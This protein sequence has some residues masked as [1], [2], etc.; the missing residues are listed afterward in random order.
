LLEPDQVIEPYEMTLNTMNEAEKREWAENILSSLGQK[1]YLF[2]DYFVILAGSN[3]RKY[4]LP[5]IM[6]YEVPFE[7]LPFGK[8]LS[9]LKRRTLK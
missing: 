4:L 9:E 2:S 7:G 1:T 8:L 5:K 6:N 3:Y